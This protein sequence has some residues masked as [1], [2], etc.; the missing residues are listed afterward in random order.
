MQTRGLV[1]CDRK[2][3]EAM[4]CDGMRWVVGGMAVVAMERPCCGCAVTAL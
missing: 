3:W 2:R 4:G 1:G